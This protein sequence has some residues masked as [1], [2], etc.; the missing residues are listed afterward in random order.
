MLVAGIALAGAV[1]APLRYVVDR[2]VQGRTHILFPLGTFV[3]N[4][5]GSFL[6]GIIAGLALYH[7]FP[8]TPTTILGSGF[9]GGYTTFSTFT[10]E[11]LA[12]LRDAGARRGTCLRRRA[13]ERAAERGRSG[14]RRGC[15]PCPGSAVASFAPS[16][17]SECLRGEGRRTAN[18]SPSQPGQRRPSAP[19][20]KLLMW[21]HFRI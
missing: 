10:Y 1:G 4:V 21:V 9:C 2:F 14:A 18:L 17:G 6:L 16:A 11:T 3:I 8:S 7:S 15:R 20:C 19:P 12:H 13:L 5:S